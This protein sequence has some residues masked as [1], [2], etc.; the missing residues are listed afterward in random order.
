MHRENIDPKMS[1]IHFLDQKQQTYAHLLVA[2]NH[3]I[4]RELGHIF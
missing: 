3:G 2:T 1:L 4:L